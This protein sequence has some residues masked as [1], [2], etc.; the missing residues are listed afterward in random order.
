MNRKAETRA[1]RMVGIHDPP[2]T[3]K[4]QDMLY[5]TMLVSVNEKMCEEPAFND[6]V[7]LISA[8]PV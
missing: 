1:S 7:Y 6:Y 3:D 4:S 5:L 8:E 2:I